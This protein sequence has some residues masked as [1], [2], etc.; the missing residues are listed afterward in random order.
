MTHNQKAIIPAI[1]Y[2]NKIEGPA[3]LIVCD[4]PKNNPVPI[5]PP[6]AMS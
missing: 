3:S 6:S 5:A 1:A 4:R 2:P